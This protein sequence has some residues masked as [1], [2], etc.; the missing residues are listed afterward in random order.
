[1]AFVAAIGYG[2]AKMVTGYANDP[3]PFDTIARTFGGDA[4]SAF[5]DIAGLLSFFAAALAIVNGGARILFTVGRDG[6]MPRWLGYAHPTRHT[7]IAAVTALCVLGLV[8]GLAL[9]FGLTPIGAFGFLGL[10]DALFV[11]LIYILVSVACLR[12]FRRKRREQFNLLRNGILPVLGLIITGVLTLLVIAS[13]LLPS[14]GQP[15]AYYAIPV[16]VAVWLAL[17]IVGSLLVKVSNE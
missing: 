3:A 10:L 5:V 2:P 1:M 8:S 6:L 9:G 11:L 12:F 15:A 13:T 17:G 14:T 16:V 7:P 4:L